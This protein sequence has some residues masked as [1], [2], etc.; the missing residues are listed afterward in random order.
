MDIIV[1]EAF[2]VIGIEGSTS[3]G[4]GFV[5]KLWAEANAH[6]GEVAHLAKRNPDGSFAGFWG[7]MSDM[8]RRY[9]PWSDGFTKGLYLAG[10]EVNADAQPPEGWVRWDMPGFEF[11]RIA[12]D[13]PDAFARGLRLL[14]NNR[15]QLTGAVQDFTDPATG[16]NYMLFP[17][18][19]LGE[20]NS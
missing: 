20:Q 12:A 17:I 13:S 19:R 10:V 9:Q 11:V 6:F 15:L 16:A 7:A 18:R 2:S 4:E 14:E 3:M 5:Q 8:E 1:K